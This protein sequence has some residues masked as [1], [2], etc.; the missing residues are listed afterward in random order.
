MPFNMRT[1]LSIKKILFPVQRVA[2][3]EASRAAAIFFFFHFIFI[4]HEN[5]VNFFFFFF[6]FAKMKKKVSSR[7]FLSH[8]AGLPETELFLWTAL[9]QLTELSELL[10]S[11]LGTG[12]SLLDFLTET[13][14]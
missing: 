10:V 5:I 6:F 4:F 11:K 14:N 2:K 7:T 1:R 9:W 8:P 13:Y 3:I 12:F